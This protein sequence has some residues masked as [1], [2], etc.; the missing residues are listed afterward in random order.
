M[1]GACTAFDMLSE[2]I[3]VAFLLFGDHL[4]MLYPLSPFQTLI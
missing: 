2:A 3:Q 4:D 1:T